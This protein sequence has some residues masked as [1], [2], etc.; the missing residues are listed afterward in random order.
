MIIVDKAEKTTINIPKNS[1]GNLTYNKPNVDLSDYYTKEQVDEL[2]ANTTIS[3]AV[4]DYDENDVVNLVAGDISKVFEDYKQHKP[5]MIFA[6]VDNRGKMGIVNC[7]QL[8]L[9]ENGYDN[10]Y[11][12]GYV[13]YFDGDSITYRRY[14]FNHFGT[15]GYAN[16][17]KNFLN[18]YTKG[19]VNELI[20]NVE[21]DLT[22]YYTKEEIDDIVENTTIPY[23]VVNDDFTGYEAGDFESVRQAIIN[24]KPYSIYIPFVLGG[25]LTPNAVDTFG[26]QITLTYVYHT[27][28]TT[29]YYGRCY[30]HTDNVNNSV[31]SVSYATSEQLTKQGVYSLTI[32]Y[33]EDLSKYVFSGASF[34]AIYSRIENKENQYAIYL[35]SSDNKYRVAAQE[36][37]IDGDVIKCKTIENNGATQTITNWTIGEDED[38][39]E[40]YQKGTTSTINIA[41]QTWVENN[42]ASDSDVNDEIGKLDSSLTSKINQKQ[43]T[44]VSGENIKTINGN[45]LLGSGDIIIEGGGS[46]NIVELTQAEYDALGDNVD[47]D[48]LYLISD[49]TISANYKTINGE[50]ILGE[51]NIE[52]SGGTTDLSD[53]YTKTECD[54]KFQLKGNYL[55]SI[56]SEY[57][58]ESELTA[59][60]YATKS[61]IPTI[62][63]NVSSFTN[64]AGYITNTALD[65]YAT[66][67]YV[68]DT[69]QVKGN[70]LTSV[71]DEYVT[72]TEL[73][74]KGYATT[75][76]VDTQIGNINTILENIIG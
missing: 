47:A 29:M 21:V 68:S 13:N 51:G 44:L 74:N 34:S 50:S 30:L 61:E 46:S 11:L 3:Y 75:T 9:E 59:K 22:N 54:G 67:T 62:P 32:Y 27:N 5:I 58:T 7:L 40:Y 14:T 49:A 10:D 39:F 73:T 71:P 25:Y 48:T 38:G 16:A 20:D 53:Y 63:T 1:L 17:T 41:T 60:N 15:T 23:L 65:G 4:F 64:D 72:D 6:P 42:F 43:D 37:V 8:L 56:P 70:Y 45:S 52:I 36:I 26:G 57:V 76:Y 12:I 69:Y 31:E 35:P 55:T 2:I 66:E 24:K 19:E 28:G 33:D 18:Y